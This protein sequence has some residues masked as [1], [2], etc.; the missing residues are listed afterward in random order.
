MSSNTRKPFSIK[1]LRLEE[2]ESRELL[3]A[4]LGVKR[5]A[6]ELSRIAKTPGPKVIYGSLEGEGVGSGNV[7]RG[8]DTFTA[9]GPEAP[10]G[11]GTF[12]G[13]ARY[14]AA[15]ESGALVGYNLANGTGTLTDSSG[16][17]LDID[18]SGA[19]YESGT[20][21]A[22]SWTGTVDGGTG[23]FKH[24]AGNISAYGTYSIATGELSVLSYQVT[25]LRT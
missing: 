10:L 23:E 21:Y 5:P 24:A 2:L 19:I 12:D 14:K 9:A 18:Y 22:F 3:S 25:L 8:T 17:R 15:F 11:V 13:R 20:T 7:R 4:D 6:V 16:D 1:K